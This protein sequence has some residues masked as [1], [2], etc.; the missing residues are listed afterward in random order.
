[1]ASKYAFILSSN[2]LDKNYECVLAEDLEI[3]RSNFAVGRDRLIRFI[4]ANR[5]GQDQKS[6]E[7]RVFTVH[8]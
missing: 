8:P 6:L 7:S 3:D 4:E 2:L 5:E 1:M